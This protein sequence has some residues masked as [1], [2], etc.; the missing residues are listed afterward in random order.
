VRR[1]RTS[2]KRII[3]CRL[4]GY[5]IQVVVDDADGVDGKGIDG[6]VG[7]AESRLLQA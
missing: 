4:I 7:V 3:D 6:V 1:G 2:W 5:R